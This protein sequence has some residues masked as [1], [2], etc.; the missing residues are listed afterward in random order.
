MSLLP[1]DV[2]LVPKIWYF[3]FWYLNVEIRFRIH[4]SYLG[5]VLFVFKCIY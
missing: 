2:E 3:K 4:K 1:K 5:F